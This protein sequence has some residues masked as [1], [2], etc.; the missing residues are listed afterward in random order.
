MGV[1]GPGSGG[2]GGHGG[3]RPGGGSRGQEGGAYPAERP[4]R[5]VGGVPK[6]SLLAL[7]R[8]MIRPRPTGGADV[9]SMAV[10]LTCYSTV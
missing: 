6:G 10:A 8:M 1:C 3:L 9:H 7:C 5:G 4:H 2:H